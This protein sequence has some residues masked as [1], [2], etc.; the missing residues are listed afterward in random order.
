MTLFFSP[1]ACSF[2]PHIVLHELDLKHQAQKVDLRAKT[3]SGGDYL[4]VNPKGYVPTL[5][6]G[7]GDKLTETAAILQYLVDQKP[8]ANLAPPTGTMGRYHFIE[9]LTFISTEMHKG[10]GPLWKRDT[11][12]D[13]KAI[14]IQHLGARFSFL[15]EHFKT[16]TFLMGEQFTA[17]DAY[18][19]T[20]LN[21]THFLK[22][23]V[24]GYPSMEGY[25]ERVGARPSVRAAK[26]MESKGE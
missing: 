18:L 25:M 9:W 17:A 5:E 1:G 6:L 3:W 4:K 23:D 15:N 22:I 10:I 8:E 16:N 19:Y 2:A 26:M 12:A 11:P 13:Y 21:W 24:T 20:I 14:V 7:N